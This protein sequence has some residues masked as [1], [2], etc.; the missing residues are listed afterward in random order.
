MY[1]LFNTSKGK[2]KS[3]I[4][5]W[6]LLLPV[7]SFAQSYP[8]MVTALVYPPYSTQFSYY[9]DHP[10]KI[11]VSLLNTSPQPLEVYL[12]GNFSGDNGIDIR[13][14]DGYKPATPISLMPNIPFQ[15]TQYNI[16]DVFSTNNLVYSG[17]TQNELM[18]MQGLPEGN[19]QICFTAFDF[20]SDQ[21]L[22]ADQPGGCSN[23]FIIQYVDPPDIILPY[24]GDSLFVSTP[25]NILFSWTPPVGAGPE[26]YYHFTMVEMYP[27]D[28]NPN[29]AIASAVPPFFYDTDVT[30]NQLLMGT[31][32]PQLM[33]G[34]SYAFVV[35]AIDPYNQI[36]FKNE[37]VSEACWFNYKDSGTSFVQSD[38]LPI[39]D[40]GIDDFIGDFELIPNTIINGQLLYKLASYA[41]SGASGGGIPSG[42][43]GGNNGWDYQNMVNFNMVNGGNA[44]NNNLSIGGFGDMGLQQTGVGN[45]SLQPPYGTG[46]INESVIDPGSAEPLRNTMIRLVVR[47]GLVAGDGFFYT[48]AGL[49]GSGAGGSINANGYKF[50]DLFGNEV[51]VQKVLG[52]VNKVL[53]VVTT[54]TQGNY[55]FNFQTDFFSG[56]IYA[57]SGA[58]GFMQGDLKGVI[59]LKVEVINQKFCSPD[60]EIFAKPG[61]ALDIPSQVALIKDF[62][63][64][65][66]VVSEYDEYTG[67]PDDNTIYVGHDIKPKAIPGGEP[68]PKAIVKV[69]RD[70][71]QLNN[72]H[73][74]ILLAEGQQLGSITNNENGEFKDVFIGQ[75]DIEG[76]I[77]I[78]KLVKHW[79]VTDGEDHSPYFFSVRTRSEQADSAYE[80]TLYNYL[81]FFGDITGI[82]ISVESSGTQLLDDDA[83]WNGYAPVTYNHFY[84][85][86]QSATDREVRLEAAPPEIKGRLMVESN[87]ENIGLPD[88][89]VKLYAAYT[90]DMPGLFETRTYTNNSGFFSFKD[91]L[92]NVDE[93]GVARGPFRRINIPHPMYKS[94][95]WPPQDELAL[96][97]K[98]GELYFKEFQMEPKR[99]L[100]AKVVDENGNAV[101]AYVKVLPNSPYVKTEPRYE[102]DDNGNIYVQYEFVDV[103]VVGYGVN[104]I[105]V[106][107]L[108]NQFFPDTI[109]LAQLPENPNE[110]ISLEVSKKLHR[111]KLQVK[112]METNAT[113]ANA[114]VV[115]GDTLVYGKTDQYGYVELLFPSPGEQFQIKVIAD[116]YTPTQVSYNIPV[117]NTW[118]YEYLGLEPA[119]SISGSITQ[120]KS[121]QPIDSAFVYIRLQSTDGHSVY[122]ESYSAADGKYTLHGIP[123]SLTNTDIHVV[124]EGNNPSYIGVVESI[125]IDPFAYPVPS[126][127]FQL[128]AANNIDLSNI[129]GFPVSIESM[130]SK[131]G[132]GTS[133]SGFFHDLPTVP[134]FETLNENEK[135]YFKNIKI[136]PAP[137]NH[138]INPLGSTLTTETFF[139]PIKINGGFEGKFH[140]PSTWLNPQKL[141][142][143]KNGDNG[144]ISGALLLDLASFKFAYDFHGDF[145]LG[146]DT[147]H[148]DIAL[149]KSI[150]SGFPGLYLAKKYIFDLGTSFKP[151]PVNN[152]RVFGFNASS[153][154]ES[155]FYLDNAIHIGTTLHTDIQMANGM[156]SLD[157]KINAGEVEITRENIEV[158]PNAGNLISFDLEDWKVESKS[159]WS[160]D[161]TRDAIVIPKGLILTGLGVDASIKGL[162]IRPNAL[163]EGEIDMEGGLSL[164]GIT[165]L[166]LAN[167]LEPKFNYDAGVGHYRISI[168]GNAQGPAAWVNQ[169]P[170][171]SDRLEF[172]SI[173]MLSDNSS[174]LSLGKHMVFHN[175][176]DIFVD[177]IMT[178]NGFFSLAG[179]PD[180]GI[181]GFVP[182]RAVMTFT[183]PNGQLH[184]KLEPLNGAVDCNGNVVYK[185]EQKET[186]QSLSNKKY[187]AYGEFFI[188]PPPGEPGEKLSL[189][190]FLTKTPGNCYIDA[191]PGTI[192]IGKETMNVIDG[193]ISV[194]ND[195][196]GI[197]NFNCST[198]STGL[199]DENVI[200]YTVHGG[201]EA[202]GPGIKVDQIET[203]LGNL[204]MAYLFPEKALVGSLTIN[205]P[206]DMGFASLQSGAMAMR[207]DPGGFYMA[208]S[209]T[210]NM[211]QEQYL[212][213]FVLG[214]YSHDLSDV[215][216]PILKDFKKNP[217]DFSSLHGFYAIGQRNLINA[218]FPIPVAP[219]IM[220]GVKAGL[221]GYTRFDYAN[222]QFTIGGYAFV[223]AIG[224]INVPLCGFVGAEAHT[225]FNVEGGYE[226]NVM[227]IQSCGLT[228][229]AVGACGLNGS[230]N[231]INKN[232][233]SSNGDNEFSL[234]LGGNCD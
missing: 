150:S 32:E 108:S 131:A 91:L 9:V 233:L 73:P 88:A 195:S 102:Y 220:V 80:N 67:N 231:I 61:D 134:G 47:F 214:D 59:S 203:P 227:F 81:P 53:D 224:G 52:T 172:T 193:N 76:N 208:F 226:N 178:G 210:I 5:I 39:V 72:E 84:M 138:K 196:W 25:Q 200:T 117:G 205:G 170:T 30:S 18:N 93:N 228:N 14:E 127:D 181:P 70:V 99:L 87:M 190:G 120:K 126:Y 111:L 133:I 159:G 82:R 128:T 232:K 222:P 16:G 55:S 46:T 166:E 157:L 43:G 44:N 173:G 115:V 142:L 187:T 1:S 6:L 213:G 110:R 2:R 114:D 129:W 206:L 75:T 28:R 169:L 155:A 4:L 199:D 113:I 13:T 20:Y 85:P 38:S 7:L 100:K 37:G 54:D 185:L 144:S 143:K 197:L 175:V 34:R 163:R 137:A 198:N 201:I 101:A 217:P 165:K 77:V 219:P 106:Q 176:L 121:G 177:Q 42:Y 79:A 151:I 189:K 92:V 51:S 141:E 209:G 212:G 33:V 145:Y 26:V 207:F 225:F 57:A 11:M 90:N 116:N 23:F 74:S 204:N 105:E 17:I 65:L 125:A 139:V 104:R 229:V 122:L 41:G 192:E 40:L 64:H 191:I 147:L 71:Q 118:H 223:D 215:V 135:V 94:I 174:V 162:N 98:Y 119:T 136:D 63:L 107:P 218:S 211:L 180:L 154:F 68:I 156:P 161:K 83:G 123:M 221:G 69:L 194:S 29:D 186:S 184:A 146:D 96:N 31:S 216:S 230:I 45:F 188:K 12:A 35:Q 124:K 60:V 56:P 8:V 103:P 15:L 36:V 148:N 97:L 95:T 62:D 179:M 49:T 158:K 164:G 152:F 89:E 167:G 3:R 50:Y 202:D 153:D 140:V 182:T 48:R 27:G 183:K 78:P 132:H 22:S 130:V 58:N 168:V 234:G 149:F 112:N 171:T 24:C 160:F 21:Q 109:S 10:N 86:P 19:Y 66:K